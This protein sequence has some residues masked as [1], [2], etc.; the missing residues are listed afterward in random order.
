MLER[1]RDQCGLELERFAAVAALERLVVG[2]LHF[3]V[4]LQ[5]LLVQRRIW[6]LAARIPDR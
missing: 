5:A 6:A 4:S 2:M 3:D 1:V